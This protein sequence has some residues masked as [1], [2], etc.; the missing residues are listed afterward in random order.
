MGVFM[1]YLLVFHKR[2]KASHTITYTN[3]MDAEGHW[4]S[5]MEFALAATD[6]EESTETFLRC[7]PGQRPGLQ[8][9]TWSRVSYT[10]ARFPIPAHCGLRY[11]RRKA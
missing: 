1:A 9:V 3:V 7:R 4:R 11:S 6:T 8:L 2:V 5:V 10:G